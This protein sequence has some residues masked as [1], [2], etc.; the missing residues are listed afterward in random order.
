MA[1]KWKIF[2]SDGAT[3]SSKDGGPELAPARG[4]QVIALSDPDHGWSTQSGADYYVWEDRGDGH[5]WWGIINDM[6]LGVYLDSPGW[7]KI[8]IGHS[9][10]SQVFSEI[11]AR[12]QADP[13]FGS[14]TGF[15]RR[16]ARP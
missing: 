5:R 6:A 11:F 12:A 15:R 7:K 10:P 3:F 14:K 13:D 8:L 9:I 16:E 1:I 2:Y 4:V